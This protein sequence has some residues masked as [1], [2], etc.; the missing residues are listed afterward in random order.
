MTDRTSDR[1]DG[2][3]AG[4]TTGQSSERT[5]EP[6]AG[7]PAVRGRRRTRAAGPVAGR[8][9]EITAPRTF[10]VREQ[11]F[12]PPG[13]GQ[14]LVKVARVGI[15]ASDLPE[16]R[17]GPG[18][19]P[20]LRLGHEPVGTVHLLGAGVEGLRVGQA[21]T[22]R[23]VPAFADYV[24]ADPADVVP[25]PEGADPLLALGEPLGCVV[26]GFRRA[27]PAV[28]DRTAVVGLG[29]MGLVMTR[30]LVA[31]PTSRV[32]AIDPRADARAVAAALGAAPALAPDDP[33]LAADAFELVV[34]ASGTQPGL[35]LATTLVAEHGTLS[36]L[37]FHR[38]VREVDVRAWN[39]KA[40]DV[41]NAHVRDR[42]RLADATRAALRLLAAGR[43]DIGS[44]LTHDLP[45]ERIGEA[46]EALESKPAGFVKAVVTL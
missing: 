4:R 38:S 7:R 3:A 8:V 9:A 29:F 45:L 39:W 44:L 31:S 33:G 23:L 10:T 22:G 5:A 12:D 40:I 28:G 42:A 41:V 18:D 13:P 34:E 26:E 32:C 27:A 11:R 37:G 2:R 36:V 15:C 24:L 30:L 43:L 6:A 21:V 19:G 46:Y 1:E 14:V 35:D 16:W 17:T 20:P 25:V